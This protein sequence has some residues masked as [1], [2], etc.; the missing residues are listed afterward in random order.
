VVAGNTAV[1]TATVSST[2]AGTPTG[3]VQFYSNGASIGSGT[4]SGGRAST[5]ATLFTAT[6]TDAIT[7]TYSGDTNFSGSNGSLS[8]VVTAATAAGL[9]VS[10]SPAALSV[11][12]GAA[13]GNTSTITVG[14]TAPYYGTVLLTCAV[15]FGGGTATDA[16]GCSFA[17]PTLTYAGTSSATSVLTVTTTTPHLKTGAGA[18][19]NKGGTGFG[20]MAG[21]SFAGLVLLLMPGRRRLRGGRLLAVLL[22]A[23]GM[24]GMAGC[25]SSGSNAAGQTLVGTSAGAYTVT[26]TAMPQ[27]GS[28]AATTVALTVQ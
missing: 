27:G 4:L 5:A 24:M 10:A 18:A 26:V 3:T 16:P 15:A 11:A 6:G 25:G 13:T 17:S 7:T 2:S 21:I 8:F 19:A 20:A 9:T 14:T 28:A 22:M 23:A 1:F 12:P